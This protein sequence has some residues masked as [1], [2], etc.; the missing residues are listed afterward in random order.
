M[1]IDFTQKL[2]NLRG[3][4]LKHNDKDDKEVQTTLRDVC[5]EAMLAV[6]DKDKNEGGKAR[7]ERWELAG[8]IINTGNV[9]E[10]KTEEISTIKERVGMIYGPAIVGPVYDL[11]EKKEEIKGDKNA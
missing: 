7:Y 3:K 5:S 4:P 6:T 1:K 10:L 11:L 8:K 9:V 2:V